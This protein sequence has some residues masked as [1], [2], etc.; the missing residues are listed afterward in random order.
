MNEKT[1]EFI[2]DKT[3]RRPKRLQN[4]V[5]ALYASERIQLQPGEVKKI[6]RK[7][8][9]RLQKNL[10]GSCT[11]LQTFSDNGIK[12]LNS[13]HISLE[14]N[15]ASLNQPIDLPRNLVLEVFNRNIDNI[16]QL[17][18]KQ[19]MGFFLILRDGG[20]EIRHIYQ[21]EH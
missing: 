20:E 16:F 2:Y 14:S 19:E 7:L 8:K 15:T 18:K 21:K 11:L 17:K 12:L 1:V 3:I 10:V 4:N 6:N 9:I 13:Q 5:F